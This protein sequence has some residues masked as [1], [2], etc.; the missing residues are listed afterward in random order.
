M[1][2]EFKKFILRGNLVDLAIGFTV[3]AAFT[4]VAKSLV[5][6]VI[7]PVVGLAIGRVDFEDFFLV[8]DPGQGTPPFN[9]IQQA[10]DMG[11]VTLNYGLFV[12]NLITLSIV[13][14]V[15][16]LLI[17]TMNRLQDELVDDEG[18]SDHAPEEPDNKK[19]VFC[20]STI[21][22]RAIRCPARTSELPAAKKGDRGAAAAG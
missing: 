9:T 22:Y 10:Q 8:L 11:A 17:R 5:D 2:T 16:F 18:T 14:I 1:L 6:D 19:C 13:G 15:M 20:R 12:N 21:P 4:S 7:M 3:G